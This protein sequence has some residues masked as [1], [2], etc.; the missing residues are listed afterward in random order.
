[1]GRVI[2]FCAYEKKL[3]QLRLMNLNNDLKD[4]ETQHKKD[5]K[6][7]L[8][9]KMKKI[10]NELNILYLQ[11]IGRK[12][13]FTKQKHYESGSKSTKLLERK[14]Q[15]QQTDNTIYK[16]RD[17]NSK[18]VQYKQDEIQ[19]NF[20]RYYK[21]LYTQPH[22]EDEQKIGKFLDSPN[23]LVI[24]EEQN[25]TLTTALTETELNSAIS[26]LKTNKV[27]P[28]RMAF[29]QSGIRLFDLY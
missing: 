26:K 6:T 22:L 12:M 7:N 27:S 16:I 3:M 2:S 11:E 9:T 29:R 14:L 8:M 24:S 15:K 25:Q 1:M 13:A 5:Q 21:L 23:L 28:A 20:K 18:T 19:K 4:L 17:L 10:R